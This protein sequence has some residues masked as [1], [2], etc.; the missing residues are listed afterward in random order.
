M[1]PKRSGSVNKVMSSAARV[2]ASVPIHSAW[3][4]DSH[5]AWSASVSRR[6]RMGRGLFPPVAVFEPDNVVLAEIAAGLHFDQVQRL[7]ADVL[8]P[9][10]SA[11]R[12]V[13]RHVL[14]QHDRILIARD[15]RR[16]AHPHPVLGALVMLL[17]GDLGAGLDDDALH[18]E[19]LAGIDG[20]VAAPGPMD[21]GV[22]RD[23]AAA[24]A[25]ELVDDLLHILGAPFVHGE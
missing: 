16:A 17:Q 22:R 7:S 23:L 12:D 1:A 11:Q 13:D 15:P 8:E 9:M 3:R 14:A 18:L 19:A 4:I 24:P 10:H 25:P 20:L 6:T 2:V 5:A 21:D